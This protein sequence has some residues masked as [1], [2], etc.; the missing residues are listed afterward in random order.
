[1]RG[2]PNVRIEDPNPNVRCIRNEVIGQPS[3]LGVKD[4]G[5][6][7]G[8]NRLEGIIAMDF[9][10][11]FR[12]HLFYAGKNKFEAGSDEGHLAVEPAV[13]LPVLKCSPCL[14]K[15]A[16]AVLVHPELIVK[17]LNAVDG[18]SDAHDFMVFMEEVLRC[19]TEPQLAVGGEADPRPC[20]ER[21][22]TP[23]AL[24]E[25]VIRD[26]LDQLRFQKRLA[27]DEIQNDT[28]SVFVDKIAGAVLVKV[29]DV[30]NDP[31]PSFQTHGTAAFVVLIAI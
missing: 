26:L 14:F 29:D 16:D 24:L 31:L 18:N 12:D 13:F 22:L 6:L 19:I 20:P 3:Q 10:A 2:L 9:F 11:P 8:I 25:P 30:I 1:M 21:A 27:T 28:L 4:P 15:A 17:L 23:P 7:L 5:F